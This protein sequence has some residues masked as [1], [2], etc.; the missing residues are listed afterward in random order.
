M[1]DHHLGTS[2]WISRVRSICM[3]DAVYNYP[4]HKG[5]QACAVIA[6]CGEKR[7]RLEFSSIL[8]YE[9]HVHI[10]SADAN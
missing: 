8:N 9:V 3:P 6:V 1:H 10:C 2:G 7:V 4:T 5:K